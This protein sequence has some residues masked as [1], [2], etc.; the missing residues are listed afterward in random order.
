MEVML[1]LDVGIGSGIGEVALAAAAGEVSALVVLPLATRVLQAVHLAINYYKGITI[2]PFLWRRM[3]IVVKSG[4][5]G[6]YLVELL[7]GHEAVVVGV[8]LLHHL[9][10]I[11]LLERHV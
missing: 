3:I 8:C 2:E 10:E 7:E 5:V 6:D 9:L 1:V 4:F 11:D